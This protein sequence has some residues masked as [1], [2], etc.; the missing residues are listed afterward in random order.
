MAVWTIKCTVV[1]PIATSTCAYLSP[2][3]IQ[4]ALSVL[5]TLVHRAGALYD[6]DSLHAEVVFRGRLFQ[7]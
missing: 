7:A 4:Q 2:P 1:L 3:P 6:Q 5:Y